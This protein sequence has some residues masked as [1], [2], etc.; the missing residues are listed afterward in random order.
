MLV[1][2]KGTM[3][4]SEAAPTDR[5]ARTGWVAVAEE[6]A[7]T[8]AARAAGHDADDTFVSENYADLR[9]RRVFSA[10]VPAELGAAAPRIPRCARC[11]GGWPA[12]ARP[13]RRRVPCT[14]TRFAPAWRW[15]HLA[16]GFDPN[17]REGS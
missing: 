6:L 8:F 3:T 12:H 16:L 7:P 5:A 4:P 2:G 15:R 10:P 11:S 17:D 14:R 1:V 13:R 9:R